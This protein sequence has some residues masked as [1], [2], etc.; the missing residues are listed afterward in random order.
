MTKRQETLSTWYEICVE[1]GEVIR[2][3]EVRALRQSAKTM[4][5][6]LKAQW[7]DASMIF[8]RQHTRGKHG[9]RVLHSLTHRREKP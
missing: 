6:T 4:V 1:E 9:F 2:Q 8:V 3:V 7:P 5:E